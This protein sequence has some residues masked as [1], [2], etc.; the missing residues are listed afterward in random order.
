MAAGKYVY[1]V[2]KSASGGE[3]GQFLGS[4][5]DMRRANCAL[6]RGHARL[7]LLDPFIPLLTGHNEGGGI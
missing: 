5:L 7:G 6:G 4:R 2:V 3:G 1:M